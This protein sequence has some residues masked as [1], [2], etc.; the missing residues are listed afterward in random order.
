MNIKLHTVISDITGQTGTAI[1]EAIIAEERNAAAF[2]SLVSSR[3]KADKD[4]IVKSLEGTWRSEPLFTLPQSYEL[5]RYYKSRM[6][7]AT[8]R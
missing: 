8:G 1:V 6:K 2:L 5:Y 7:P 4:T 3:I